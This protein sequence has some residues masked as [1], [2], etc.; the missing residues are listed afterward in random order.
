MTI[1]FGLVLLLASP[2]AAPA[3]AA[4]LRGFTPE[5]SAWQRDYE[6]RLSELPKPAEC[7]A[8]LRELTREPH[9]AGTPGNERVARF[10]AEEFRKAGLEVTTPT[11]DVLL[12]Y[13]KSAKL[14]IVGEPG[15]ALART[16]EP[17]A[18]D[19]D[20]AIA[21]SLP[22]WNAYAPSADL[23]AEVV[24]VNRGS[25]EDYDRLAAMGIDVRG[26][27]ALA[28]YF[29]GYRGGKSLE[30]EKRGVA[31]LL[32]YSDPIDDGWY[33]GEV[34][35]PG[36]WGPV[37]HFQRGANVYDFLVAGDPLTPGWASTA[38][39]RRIAESES[40]IL[41][42][43]PMMPLSS[44]DAA[45]LLKR[46]K[47]PAVPDGWQGLA[48]A[49]TYRV[50]PGPLRVH[51]AIDNTRERRPIRNVIGVLKG[52]DEPERKILLSNHHDAWVYGAVD[53]SSGTATI[54]S[55]ARALGALAR[56]GLRPRRTI[57]FGSWDAE[58]YTLTGST[59]WG[60]EN[61]A[62][63]GRNAVVCINVDASTS[64][65]SF[66]ASASPL[67]FEVIRD[68]AADVADPGVP[69]KSVAETWRENSGRT[70]VRSYATGASRE[71]A[72]PVA[73]L[74]SGSDYTVFFNR[75][76]VPS[77]DLVFDGPYGVY[78]SIYDDYNWMATAGDPGF[79]YHAAMARYAGSLA[80][81]FANADVLPFD[82]SA[83][84]REI[85]RY[86]EELAGDSRAAALA[87]DLSGLARAA[88]DWSEAA[89]SAQK[90]VEDR[91]A[92]G[93]ATVPEKAAANRWLLSLERALLDPVGLPGRPWFRHL[94]YAPLPSYAAETLP[95]IREAST[96]GDL[97]AARRGVANLSGRLSAA[98]AEARSAAG[99]ASSASAPKKAP[100]EI[101][102]MREFGARYAA[103]WSS[104]DPERLASFFAPNG[105]LRVNRGAPS[106]GRAAIT[107]TARGF[108]T[109][110]P[111][112]AVTMDELSADGEDRFL[113]RWTWT[114]TNTGPGGTGKA[115][116]IRGYEEWTIGA[117][118]LIAVSLGHVDEDEYRRQLE[119][120]AGGS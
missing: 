47:G 65:R 52:S 26:R 45:E 98:A 33:R 21:A 111:D 100:M 38:G 87:K 2:A 8:L 112:M 50:G 60:E 113:F 75:L 117:D 34:Y 116:R 93:N 3:D 108:M 13:S 85:A 115:V 71:E 44:R 77:I 59:E 4:R 105:S 42:K 6:R 35:P 36:P 22:P 56:Q 39:A 51:L 28:R 74:G 103:A 53:P 12:S 80:L 84:G 40:V 27:I 66:S 89:G 5:R 1:A 24:Y 110:F 118:G 102:R 67:A 114:G 82:A 31:G 119:T 14:E 10:I 83:Y 55:L 76:G 29:G 104:G 23:T 86:A 78:H 92:S 30:G 57:V 58:E 49:D 18:S 79:L 95:A 107:E 48:I 63:L 64:G 20:T 97:D 106:V 61:E 17:I 99:A 72:L 70:N 120:G 94:V 46:L 16:E 15:V 54:I 109:A 32:V 91:I 43:I 62:D 90:A 9:V 19:P 101:A 37:S 11:Y 7:D 73:I 88:R 69:G 81:R 25:A 41:P 96:A 68:T